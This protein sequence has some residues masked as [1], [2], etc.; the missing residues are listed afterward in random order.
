MTSILEGEDPGH[1]SEQGI[2]EP[3]KE[4]LYM[5]QWS[6]PETNKQGGWWNAFVNNPLTF[7]GLAWEMVAHSKCDFIKVCYTPWKFKKLKKNSWKS[8]EEDP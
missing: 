2:S 8:K 1:S 7:P 5:Y 6:V 4:G 3:R